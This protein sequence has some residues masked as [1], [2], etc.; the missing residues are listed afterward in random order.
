MTYLLAIG[1]ALFYGAA[2]F[3]GGLATRRAGAIPVVL[4]SQASGLVLLALILPFL[5]HA[6]P[7]RADLLWGAVAGLTGG[8]GVALLYRALAIG[9]MAV[10][11][12]TTA[13]CAVTIPVVVSVLLGERPLPLAI[14]GI[15]L[16]IVSIL[17]VSRQAAAQTDSHGLAVPR[18]LP[19]GVGTAFA[20]GVAIGFFFLSLAQTGS[21]AGMWPLIVARLFSVT[22]FGAVA[23]AGARS[24]RMPAPVV[25]L[26]IGGGIMDMVANALYMLA[27]RQGPLSLV[28]TLSSLYPA[29][30]VLLARVVLAERLNAWQISGVGCALAAIVLIV[31]GAR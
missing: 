29:S 12:P 14:A 19:A 25:A 9:T 3:S 16:G 5:A 28:V 31:S 7:S 23:V 21:G 20:S 8:I 18:R 22:L 4:L 13:V 1:S 27:A 11:A 17:L 26:A 2:D 15:V 24:I 10:V 6:S 30:T